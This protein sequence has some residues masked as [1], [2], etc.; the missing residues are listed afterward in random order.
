[1]IDEI[2]AVYEPI[3]L[4]SNFDSHLIPPEDFVEECRIYWLNHTPF[5]E[6]VERRIGNTWYTIETECAGA[7]HLNDKVKRLIFS[8][9]N[10]EKEDSST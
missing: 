9:K 10:F 4:C 1:M 8:D 6:A 2:S 5:H 3:D 7:E